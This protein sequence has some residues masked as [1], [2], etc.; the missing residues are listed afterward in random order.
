VFVTCPPPPPATREQ[1]RPSVSGLLRV[2]AAS[3]AGTVLMNLGK[4]LVCGHWV[5]CFPNAEAAAAA[6]A[7]AAQQAHKSRVVFCQL[8]EP[9]LYP[10]WGQAQQEPK[11]RGAE[12]EGA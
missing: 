4:F 6:A 3:H 11:S 2:V 9:L 12:L 7:T 1:V 10:T 5:L 8:L